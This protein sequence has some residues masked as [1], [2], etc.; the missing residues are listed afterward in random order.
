MQQLNLVTKTTE[1][2][3]LQQRFLTRSARPRLFWQM[4]A[5]EPII[6]FDGVP[7]ITVGQCTDI[8][9]LLAGK[10]KAA[11]QLL[12]ATGD[13]L[14]TKIHTQGCSAKISIRRILRYPSSRLPEVGAVQGITAMRK[15][16]RQVLE[17]LT[18]KICA[19]LAKP[20]QRY[21]FSL[22]TPLAHDTHI[23]AE[24][25]D[26]PSLIEPVHDQI[27]TLISSAVTNVTSIHDHIR[28][29]VGK[30]Y[31]DNPSKDDP[32]FNPS[33]YDLCR[34]I[35]WLYKSGRVVDQDCPFKERYTLSTEEIAMINKAASPPLTTPTDTPPHSSTDDNGLVNIYNMAVDET[36]DLATLELPGAQVGAEEVTGTSSVAVTTNA[37]TPIT[38]H[39]HKKTVASL[40]QNSTPN[41]FGINDVSLLY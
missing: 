18:A 3:Y 6:H 22:P 26:P 5:G 10:R 37:T 28:K 24:M 15:L 36:A 17:V 9:C 29:Y 12:V 20:T 4:H 14:A 1:D 41:V 39:T 19:G 21:Y 13:V 38:P 32:T 33:R 34:Y 31:G 2:S 25:E 7:F 30:T 16:R 40:P 8:H 11:N 23:V 27:L 35:Y